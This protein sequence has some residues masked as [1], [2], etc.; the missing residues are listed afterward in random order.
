MPYAVEW[1][2]FDVNFKCVVMLQQGKW[3]SH[4]SNKGVLHLYSPFPLFSLSSAACVRACV[5]VCVCVC[6]C[7]CFFAVH[8]LVSWGL[9]YALL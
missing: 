3:Q 7:L 1:G 8:V 2:W 9:W 5:S 6:L 4:E